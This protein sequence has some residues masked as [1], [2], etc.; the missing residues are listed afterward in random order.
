[1]EL[2]FEDN[3]YDV[4]LAQSEAGYEATVNGGKTDFRL[5]QSAAGT[6]LIKQDGKNLPAYCAEDENKLYVRINE[7]TYVFDKP[8]EEEKSF[9]DAIANSADKQLVHPPMPGSIVKIQVKRDSRLRKGK[10]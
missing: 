8:K 4:A 9:D 1:M 3:S 6:Y 5:T 10:A 2:I 7:L